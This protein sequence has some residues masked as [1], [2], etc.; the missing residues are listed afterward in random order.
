MAESAKAAE[1]KE[2]VESVKQRFPA[3]E[4]IGPCPEKLRGIAY[5]IADELLL[6]GVRLVFG[7]CSEKVDWIGYAYPEVNAVKINLLKIYADAITKCEDPDSPGLSLKASIWVSLITCVA[8]E[9]HHLHTFEYDRET[10]DD[11]K[12]DE[13]AANEFADLM[14]VKLAK[15]YDIEPPT[16]KE[17]PYFGERWMGLNIDPEAKIT[18]MVVKERKMTEEGLILWDEPVGTKVYSFQEFVRVTVDPEQKDPEFDQPVIDVDVKTVKDGEVEKID[19]ATELE[20]LPQNEYEVGGDVKHKNRPAEVETVGEASEDDDIPYDG[21][22]FAVAMFGEEGTMLYADDG[23]PQILGEGLVDEPPVLV[24][25]PV[26]IMDKPATTVASATVPNIPPAGAA[27]QQP[28]Q[29]VPAATPANLDAAVLPQNIVEQQQRMA[30]AANAPVGPAAEIPNVVPNNNLPIETVK[31]AIH[32]IY[33]RLYA[34]LMN[35]CKRT[36]GSDIGYMDPEKILEPVS[37]SDII[38][39]FGAHG[40]VLGYDTFDRMGK[41]IT[42]KF[43]GGIRGI[44]YRKKQLPAYEIYFNL[45]GQRCKRVIVPQN[46][47]TGKSTALLARQGHAIAWVINGDLPRDYQGDGKFIAEIRDNNYMPK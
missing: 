13:A 29:A 35:D 17:L 7:E 40:L 36:M 47:A 14:L 6:A 31:Q 30:A 4:I 10:Y 20:T 42:E 11:R 15:R 1:N 44:V 45:G 46:P 12:K 43:N 21:G 24:Q 34:R 25:Q 32:A 23:E 37:I 16:W 28:A 33:M 8:H 27:V 2:A 19:K 18:D 3:I 5:V 38:Q 26:V 22:D 39:R 9:F 41:Q